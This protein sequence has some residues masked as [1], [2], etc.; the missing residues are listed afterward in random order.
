MKWASLVS[1]DLAAHLRSVRNTYRPQIL[2]G[3][4]M[5][6]NQQVVFFS[7]G[8]DNVRNLQFYLNPKT[9]HVLEWFNRVYHNKGT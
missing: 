4:G 2:K 5:Q 1:F 6:K 7:D 3:Q 9:E 8:G